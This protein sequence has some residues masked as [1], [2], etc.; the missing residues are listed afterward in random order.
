MPL[1]CSLREAQSHSEKNPES[2]MQTP[3][4]RRAMGLTLGTKESAE[5]KH[6]RANQAIPGE[7]AKR[8]PSFGGGAAAWMDWIWIRPKKNW[9]G[10]G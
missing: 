4:Y 10:S 1:Q 6:Q 3:A 5:G 2:G 8:P 9:Q 7:V